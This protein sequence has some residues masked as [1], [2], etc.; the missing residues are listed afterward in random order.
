MYQIDDNTFDVTVC[1]GAPLNYLNDNY[2]DGIKELYRVTKPRGSV[3]ISVNSRLGVIH[4]LCLFR[5][6][7]CSGW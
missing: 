1:Y 2:T 4:S 7:N 3:F 6:K 5:R